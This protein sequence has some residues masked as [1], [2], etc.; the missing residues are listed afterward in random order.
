MRRTYTQINSPPARSAANSLPMQ[1]HML[2]VVESHVF[3]QRTEC[4]SNWLKRAD[5]FHPVAKAREER[6]GTDVRPQIEHTV[7][8]LR[9]IIG[10]GAEDAPNGLHISR[11]AQ[12]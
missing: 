8:R 7:A 10:S 3:L 2:H 12:R 11:V 4:G 1:L 9:Q 5:S 6:E